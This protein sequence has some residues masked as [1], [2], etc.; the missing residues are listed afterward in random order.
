MPLEYEDIHFLLIF[1]GADN[2]NC[3]YVDRKSYS[4]G[5][6]WQGRLFFRIDR[7]GLG[8]YLWRCRHI[9]YGLARRNVHHHRHVPGLHELW[10][11]HE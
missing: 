8:N 5:S 6:Y 3:G 9:D 11:Q 1:G 7:I 4:L 10:F 2:W